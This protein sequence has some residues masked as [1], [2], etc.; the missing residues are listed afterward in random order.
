[1]MTRFE[2]W[3]ASRVAESRV[4][5]GALV[6]TTAFALS[7]TISRSVRLES[8]IMSVRIRDNMRGYEQACVWLPEVSHG[9][10]L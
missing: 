8:T 7:V 1:M 6:L 5:S 3:M 9:K 4:R 10:D 2:S